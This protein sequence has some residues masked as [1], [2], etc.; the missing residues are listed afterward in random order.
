M[1]LAFL[2]MCVFRFQVYCFHLNDLICLRVTGEQLLRECGS[3]G[4]HTHSPW[5]GFDR[6]EGPC[7]KSLRNILAAFLPP[8]RRQGQEFQD[9]SFRFLW[10]G[11]ALLCQRP[12]WPVHQATR[13]RM[14]VNLS[15]N[16]AALMAAYKEVVDS[17]L[18]TNWWAG[19]F[20]LWSSDVKPAVCCILTCVPSL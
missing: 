14:A 3:S 12:C 15:K 9:P 18:D 13:G 4:F 17:K 11:W 10:K 7:W 20:W 19:S 5:S 8:R 1:H 16:G 6:E 2:F